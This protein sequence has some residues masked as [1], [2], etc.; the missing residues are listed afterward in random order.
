[1]A[2]NGSIWVEGTELHYLTEIGT[3]RKATGTD[4]GAVA[5]NQGSLWIE[6]T[7]LHYI[8][9]AGHERI[10][11]Y[12]AIGANESGLQGSIWVESGYIRYIVGGNEN[13]WHTDTH[14][15][16]INAAHQDVANTNW[17]NGHN[18]WSDWG[19]SYNNSAY[20]TGHFNGTW[21]WSDHIDSYSNWGNAA[22]SNWTDHQNVPHSDWTNYTDA[23]LNTPI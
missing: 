10:L 12:T 2:V 4:N 14:N 7:Q 5:G 20:G 13:T 8:D 15:D 6:G 21:D 16:Q 19:D 11:P 18:D 3:E 17:S 23:H 9:N 1:M 22:Y